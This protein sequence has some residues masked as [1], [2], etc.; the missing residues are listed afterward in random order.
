MAI[1]NSIR[2]MLLSYSIVG[3]I[4]TDFVD[5]TLQH[6]SDRLAVTL[7]KAGVDAR[8]LQQEWNDLVENF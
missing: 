5:A 3:K 1:D 7:D 6:L 8:M 2:K 4:D